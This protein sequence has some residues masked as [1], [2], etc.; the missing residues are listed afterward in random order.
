MRKVQGVRFSVTVDLVL[1]TH[2][3][4]L[5]HLPGLTTVLTHS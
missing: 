2:L 5:L 4:S 1:T 3:S